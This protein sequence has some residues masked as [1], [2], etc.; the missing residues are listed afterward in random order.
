V[1][2]LPR[3]LP[4]R[5]ALAAVGAMAISLLLAG[6]LLLE[7]VSRDGR[8]AVDDSLRARADRVGDR[9]G[10][11][12]GPAARRPGGGD[13]SL[14]AGTGTYVRVLLGDEVV[15]GS[16]DTPQGPLPVPTSTGLS[17]VRVGGEQ[18]RSLVVDAPALP[19]GARL[20]LLESLAPV[21]E[22]VAST[23]RLVILFGLLAL[24]ITALAS[25]FGTSFVLRPLERLRSA[26]AGVSSTEDLRSRLPAADDDPEEVRALT[27][28]LNAMLG[29]L[30]A[31]ATTTDRALRATRRFAADAGHEL[32][33]PMTGLQAN[34][35]ALLRNP[36][37]SAD[38][39]AQALSEMA[40]DQRRMAALLAGLQA[41]ARGDSADA[42]PRE[43]VELGDVLDAA[44]QAARRR[45]PEVSFELAE[46]AADTTL[47]GWPDGLRM[48]ADNVL[49]N[50]AV[51]G[52][53]GGRV[54]VRLRA[55]GSDRLELSFSDDGPGIP[56]GERERVMERFVRGNGSRA[57]GTGLGLA[58]VAQ[59][60]ALHGGSVSLTESELGGLLVDVDLRR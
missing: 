16:G 21:D 22:R 28:S 45:H 30:E 38:E 47:T 1:R 24:A 41:L 19:Q 3:S 59:Q 18:W 44:L 54:A 33:T 10:G 37:L 5:V 50:A 53:R 35:D 60:A 26:A 23:R 40:A 25:W 55:R 11:P 32:R 51:H 29:R 34:L 17:T 8:N 42:V 57:P 36:D 39:R 52:R 31:S 6:T 9:F 27:A 46:E 49:E 13:G 58:I 14:L 2:L 4:G 15:G 56:A 43:T 7:A 20:Q 12:I 48:L